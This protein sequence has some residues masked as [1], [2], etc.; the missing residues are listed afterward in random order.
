[1]KIVDMLYDVARDV[2]MGIDAVYDSNSRLS[3]VRIRIISPYFIDNEGIIFQYSLATGCYYLYTRFAKYHPVEDGP[4][5]LYIDSMITDNSSVYS[6]GRQFRGYAQG[7]Y[8]D[9]N[10]LREYLR[11]KMNLVSQLEEELEIERLKDSKMQLSSIIS[12]RSYEN[13][14]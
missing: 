12:R 2:G 9:R 7:S 3:E 6:S 4:A 1:M 8:I 13:Q 5:Y 11:N 14:S 10:R